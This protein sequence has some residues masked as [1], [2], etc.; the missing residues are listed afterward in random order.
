MAFAWMLPAGLFIFS[1]TQYGFITPVAPIIS[2]L[3]ILVRLPSLLG[4]AKVDSRADFPPLPPAA[5]HL[6]RLQRNVQVSLRPEATVETRGMSRR[7]SDADPG[8][9]SRSFTADAYPE[10]ASS[11]IAGQGLLRNL[12]GGCTPLFANQMFNVSCDRPWNAWR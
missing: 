10:V 4:L 9:R 11:A 7:W 6:P 5:R 1:F 2:L 8:A 3:L 12:F